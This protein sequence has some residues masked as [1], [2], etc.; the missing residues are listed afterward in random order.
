MT[1]TIAS[2]IIGP[3]SR[4]GTLPIIA[5][6]F[7]I[8]D[9]TEVL[10]NRRLRCDQESHRLLENLSGRNRI[11]ATLIT[12]AAAAGALREERFWPCPLRRAQERPLAFAPSAASDGP[13]LQAL[14]HPASS[15][16]SPSPFPY[17]AGKRN[18]YLDAAG[19][20]DASRLRVP[21][22]IERDHFSPR[23]WSRNSRAGT[24]LLESGSLN[25]RSR[26]AFRDVP[27]ATFEA[28]SE[29]E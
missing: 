13:R 28:H 4:F 22:H 27:P 12:S 2:M 29:G 20:A 26:Q 6:S 24:Q 25:Q 8:P 7:P 21:T 23:V 11:K 19:R 1:S 5:R 15:V 14:R 16:D 10:R 17:H 18:E 9:S 3:Q